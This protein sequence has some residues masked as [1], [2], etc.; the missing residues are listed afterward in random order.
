M[1]LGAVLLSGPVAAQES[2]DAIVVAPLGA[3]LGSDP[4]A[5]PQSEVERLL[6]ELAKADQPGWQQ[7]EDAVW[8][9]WSK[10]GSATMDLLL[11]RGR[12][13]MDA[14]DIEGALAHFTALTDHAP[15]FAEAWNARATAFFRAGR[16]GPAMADIRRAIA[17]NPQHFGALTGLGFILEELGQDAAAFEAFRAAG[18]IHPHREDIHDAIERLDKRVMGQSI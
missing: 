1:P 17:L 12:E 7:I 4:Q 13:A 16:Y 15:E 5:E 14:G 3:D 2:G 11:S 8:R 6:S 9:E 10:S 18:A